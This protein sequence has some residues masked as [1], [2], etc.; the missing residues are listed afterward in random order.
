MFL[1]GENIYFRQLD[2]EDIDNGYLDWIND[3]NVIRYLD[4][5]HFP[6]SREQ[7][8]QY[9][10]SAHQSKDVV[11]FAV[12]E[13]NSDKHIGNVKIGPIDWVN[14]C[15]E[16]G[17]LIGPNSSRGMGIGQEITKL[18]LEYGFLTLNL[19]KITAGAVADNISSIKSNEKA[20][21]VVEGVLKEQIFSEGSYKDAV[22]LGITKTRFLQL[23]RDRRS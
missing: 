13:T 21:L 9:V 8:R 17:R 10:V 18:I 4:S 5:G 14:R 22:R 7:L 11:F 20:G 3:T 23:G 15:A 12:V 1:V 16:F 19:N 2:L 6:L